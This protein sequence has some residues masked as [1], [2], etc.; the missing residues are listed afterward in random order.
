MAKDFIRTWD[1]RRLEDWGSVVSKEFKQFQCAMKREVEASGRRQGA[2]LVDWHNGHYDMTGVLE[3]NG[4]YV[5]FHYSNIDRTKVVLTKKNS[6]WLG[7]TL[8]RTM[9]HAKDWTGGTNNNVEFEQFPETMARLFK[10]QECLNTDNQTN[11]SSTIKNE[12]TIMAS[13]IESRH[14]YVPITPYKL[15]GHQNEFNELAGIISYDNQGHAFYVSLQAGWGNGSWYGYELYGGQG[16]LTDTQWVYVLA[17]PRNSQKTIDQMYQNLTAP[18]RENNIR[19]LFDRRDWDTLKAYIK[20][21][22]LTGTYSGTINSERPNDQTTNQPNNQNKNEETMNQEPKN[23]NQISAADLIGKT[24]IIGENIATIIIK[25]ADGDTLQTEFKKADSSIGMPLPV[26]MEN[27][28]QQLSSGAWRIGGEGAAPKAQPTEKEAQ[29]PRVQ[30]KPAQEIEEEENEERRVKSEE[31]AA[32]EEPVEDD[33]NQPSDICHQTSAE[34][35]EDPVLKQWQKAKAKNPDAVII[36]RNGSVYVAVAEDAE[37]LGEVA[38]LKTAQHNG[39]AIC[40]FPGGD[41]SAVMTKAVGANLRV[42]LEDLD[43]PEERPEP[44]VKSEESELPNDPE[45]LTKNHEGSARRPEG[46]SQPKAKSQLKPSDV[47]VEPEDGKPFIRE[48]GKSI[49]V[50]GDTTKIEAVLLTMWGRKRPYT[51]KGKTYSGIQLSAKHKATVKEV[52]KLASAS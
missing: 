1:G 45:S 31:S 2:T 19:E 17:A 42:K 25:S 34:P 22:A 32:A 37:K 7:C 12:T 23:M 8:M 13:K 26:T 39:T 43:A 5:Y 41:L 52:I 49:I 36:F 30:P 9:K 3:R 44:R 16:W 51:H 21:V 33:N 29:K 10:E 11:D 27:L 40:V 48:V 14:F 4:L 15:E 50:A 18:G 24:I 6:G 35:D 47:T 20:E 46:E 28:R 38:E